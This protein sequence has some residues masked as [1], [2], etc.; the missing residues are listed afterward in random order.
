[1]GYYA[2]M[3]TIEEYLKQQIQQH[4]GS[5]K[6]FCDKAELPYM[7]VNNVI[8][9]GVVNS[10]LNTLQKI[11]AGLNTSLPLF[12][13]SY[14]VIDKQQISP[15][16]V[17]QYLQASAISVESYIHN[18]SGTNED[19]YVILSYLE[20]LIYIIASTSLDK[21]TAQQHLKDLLT[22]IYNNLYPNFN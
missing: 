21:E 12:L 4:S 13:L 22:R 8:K 19:T 11:C 7:T 1:M 3:I 10:S 18:P 17:Q 15:L 20:S 5:I 14:K 9:R 16:E 6:A 2:F